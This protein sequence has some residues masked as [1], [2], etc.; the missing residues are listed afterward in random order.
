MHH[1]MKKIL[2]VISLLFV[3]LAHSQPVVRISNGLLKGVTEGEVSI[4]KGIPFASPPVGD[5][6]WRPPQPV[7]DWTGVRD[8]TNFGPNCAQGGWG[9]AP[10]KIA[11]GSSEDCLYLNVWKPANAEANSNLP[12]MVWIHGGGFTG[13]RSHFS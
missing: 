8:A 4:F 11:E 13:G 3:F 7:K 1:D 6:R 10:G 5:F 2:F 12:V 9:T